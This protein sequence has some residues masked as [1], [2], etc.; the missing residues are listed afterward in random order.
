MNPIE[1]MKQQAEVAY[2]ELVS[3]ID[4]IDRYRRSART[5]EGRE[6]LTTL[7]MLCMDAR[8]KVEES[9]RKK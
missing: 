6:A 1:Y 4:K 2:K 3:D 5:K 7:M 9:L 8:S